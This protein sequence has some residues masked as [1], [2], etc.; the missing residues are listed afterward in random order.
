MYIKKNLNNIVS[1]I[2][3][4]LIAL[5][6]ISIL[7]TKAQSKIFKIK[8]IE[9]SEPFNADFNKETV[10]NKAFSKAFDELI[11]TI[12]TTNDKM[13][14]NN[15]KLSEIKYLVESFEIKDENFLDKKYVANLNVNFNKKNTLRFF[16]KKNIFPSLK[17]KKDFLTILIFIDND[18][19]QIF[20][21]E[22]NI[23]YKNWNKYKEKYF[24]INYIL[25]NEDI[26]DLR[27]IN[28]YKDN[29]ENLQ[30]NEIIK[31]YDLND[32]I[33]SIF[34]KNKNEL[35]ILSKFFFDN[36][37]KIIN[38]TYNK[39]NFDDENK[40]DDLIIKTKMKLEDLWKNNNLINT[41]IKLAINLEINPKKTL[42]IIN[43]EKEMN[44]IDLVYDYYITSI[45]NEKLNYKIIFNGSPKQFLKIMREKNI[46][47]DIDNELWKIK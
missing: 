20:L 31:K 42:D 46:A 19:N 37:L 4:F 27:V 40:L 12:I 2:I 5:L 28:E 11:L 14:V 9:I 26:E 41:S 45:S 35:R 13:K 32:Y 15:I 17:K 47:I 21:Y 36:N 22:N 7:S 33:V 29:I 1:Y 8:D 44:K 38:Q 39:V 6:F 3:I 10:I 30:F 23:F 16:E 43:L 34:F 24:L 18:K 25:I